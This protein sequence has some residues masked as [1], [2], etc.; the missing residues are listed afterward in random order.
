MKINEVKKTAKFSFFRAPV[1]NKKPYG[2]ITI[3]D[4]Y[5]YITGMYALERTRKLRVIKDRSEARDYKC[6]HFDYVTFSGT[7]SYCSDRCLVE[8]SSLLSL[9]FDHVGNALELQTFRNKLI[10]DRNFV[11][12]LLFVSPSGDGLKWIIS[13]DTTVCNHLTWFKALR[14]YVHATYGHEVDEQCKNV[15]RCCFLPHDSGCYV[16]PQILQEASVCPF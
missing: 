12:Q 5:K 7:F 9:D 10:A 16:N 6:S 3:A 2:A 1:T 11:T 4:A 13:I 8:H 14:N 15:S